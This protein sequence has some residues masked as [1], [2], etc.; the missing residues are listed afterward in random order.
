MRIRANQTA[1]P[2]PA[3]GA[4]DFAGDAA[5]AALRAQQC[6]DYTAKSSAGRRSAAGGW[7]QRQVY[8]AEGAGQEGAEQPPSL[9]GLGSYSSSASASVITARGAA[10]RGGCGCVAGG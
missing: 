5:M 9:C 2:L 8:R 4:D 10:G 1:L 3:S 7:A 6:Q